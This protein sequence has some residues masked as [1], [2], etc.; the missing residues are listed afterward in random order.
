MGTAARAI[1]FEFP[2]R[3][4]P[5]SEQFNWL[6]ESYDV[7][8]EQLDLPLSIPS[9]DTLLPDDGTVILLALKTARNCLCRDLD[10][11]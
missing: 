6:T 8:P 10:S 11:M 7:V 4:P 3:K 9:A 5:A 2:A 1:L